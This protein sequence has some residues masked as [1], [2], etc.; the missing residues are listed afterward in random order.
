ME[1]LNLSFKKEF[2]K[3]W[4]RGNI[5]SIFCSDTA[6]IAARTAGGNNQLKHDVILEECYVKQIGKML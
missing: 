6:I 3:K 5:L 2:K 4:N 1:R